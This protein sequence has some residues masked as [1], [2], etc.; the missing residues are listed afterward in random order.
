MPASS[1]CNISTICVSKPFFSAHLRYIRRS[2]ST[3]SWASVP[4]AP[5]L[6]YMIALALSFSPASIRS[7]SYFPRRASREA[8]LWSNSSIS[9]GSSVSFAIS[10]SISISS[11]S[12]SLPCQF[13]IS[14]WISDLRFSIFC[15]LS[16]SSQKVVSDISESNSCSFIWSV[17]RSKITSQGA[18]SFNQSVDFDLYFV[19]HIFFL[20]AKI[21]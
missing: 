5:E 18:H 2:I 1:P 3:Q 7:I 4:P 14:S 10:A 20:S 16:W 19:I 8:A 12:F 15:A 21:L 9:L 6:I 17:E 11:S 13:S